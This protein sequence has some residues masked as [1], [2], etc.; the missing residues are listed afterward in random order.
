MFSIGL[1]RPDFRVKSYNGED[2]R[3][4]WVVSEVR[5]YRSSMEDRH[6]HNTNIIDTE[7]DD[8]GDKISIFGVFDGHGGDYAA[9]WVS[10]KLTS[11]LSEEL[12]ITKTPPKERYESIFHST[13]QQLRDVVG[14]PDLT[15]TSFMDPSGTTACV[16]II[17]N[18]KHSGDTTLTCLNAGDTRAVLFDDGEIVNL[19]DD[20]KP[21]DE[22]ERSRVI[23]AG[24]FLHDERINGDLAVARS[25]GDFIH[26]CKF[27]FKE[28]EQPLVCTPDVRD[29]T[30]YNQSHNGLRFFLIASDGLW[31][32]MSSKQAANYIKLEI[33]N[34]KIE[35]GSD[36]VDI[37]DLQFIVEKLVLHSVKDL[38]SGDNVTVVLV[39]M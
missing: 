28:H 13:D 36:V 26:K 11:N 20:H 4:K 23:K 34:V 10:E 7:M 9:E 14:R 27:D 5:G 18:N 8:S 12:R 6:V 2:F 22:V 32:V 38:D 29:F 24:G 3:I 15:P 30:L 35:T 1:G 31:D 17:R 21:M 25:F 16:C 33:E 37:Q 39:V 19:S